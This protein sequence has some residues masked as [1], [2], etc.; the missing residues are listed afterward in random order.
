MHDGKVG[1]NLY[2][3][4]SCNIKVIQFVTPSYRGC[5]LSLSWQ[6]RREK[7]GNTSTA[8]D[9][10]C[11]FE[12]LEYGASTSANRRNNNTISANRII[13]VTMYSNYSF[14]FKSLANESARPCS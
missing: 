12:E 6:T 9:N 11:S 1:M 10:Y 8:S 2:W 5:Q 13:I 3:E 4:Q 14:N 7:Y